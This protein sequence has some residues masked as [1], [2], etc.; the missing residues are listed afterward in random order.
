MGDFAAIAGGDKTTMA[1]PAYASVPTALRSKPQWLLWKSEPN[2]DKKPRKVPYYLDGKRRMGVQGDVADRQALRDFAST[3][4]AFAQGGY[5]G[6]G[7]AFL[8]GDGLIGIDIDGAIDLDTGVVSDRALAIIEA[9]ASYTEYSVSRKGVHIIVEHDF[10]DEKRATFKSNDIGLEVFCGRQ[11]FTVSGCPFPGSPAQAARMDERT[12]VRLRKTVDLAKARPSTP[13]S[14]PMVC[15]TDGRAKVESALAYVPAD[16]GYHEWIEIGMAIHAELGDS[17]FSIWDAW[18]AKGAKYPGA[19]TVESH[20][21]SFKPGGGITGATIFKRAMAEGW[22]APRPQL[23]AQGSL[24]GGDEPPSPPYEETEGEEPFIPDERPNTPPPGRGGRASKA[25]KEIKWERFHELLD[26][27]VLIYSTSTCFDL[28]TRL[29][30]QVNHLRLAFG[31]DYVKMWLG[32]DLRKMILPSQLVFSPGKACEFPEINLFDGMPIEPKEGDCQPILELLRYL[33]ADSAATPD[34][35]DGVMQWVLS[36]VALPLQKPGTKMQSA[37]IFHGPEGAGKNMFWEIVARIYGRYSTVVGQKQLES[38][39]NAW[40]SQK[41]LVIGD[42]VVTRQELYHHKGDLKKFITGETIQINEKG[43]PLREESNHCNVIFLSNEHQ[44]L[45]LGDGDRRYFVVYTPPRRH[46]DLYQRVGR[47]AAA[48]GIAAFYHYLL[49]LDL[50]GFSQFD[51]TPMT[52]AKQDLIE[53]GLKPEERF[54]REWLSGY[55]PLPLMTCSASQLYRAFRRWCMAS[56]ERFPPA[57]EVFTKSA[58][59]AIDALSHKVTQA[60]G[61]KVVLLEYK[62]IKLDDPINGQRAVRMWKPEGCRPPEG[63]TE[64]KWAAT[65]V[66]DFEEYL[67]KYMTLL[68]GGDK[69]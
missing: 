39:F 20:W 62:V 64:G 60:R 48:G 8:P 61:D 68:G 18:S 31:S 32:S 25:V 49:G 46:D 53:L 65:C 16:C 19:R 44:P 27:F 3:C 57:Q 42:E 14:A 30:I 38:D 58:R 54:A 33:C 43:L 69:P 51:I 52:R 37:Q 22:R 55:L 50:T 66:N 11:Y 29:V 47:W 67:G 56:G 34:G 63:L 2:G 28:R 15:H 5:A 40:A 26:N 6:I 59:K 9:C 21:K 1:D 7:F 17:A 4:A 24:S 36:W 45:A 13:V 23:V 41:M 12:L 10:A 35:V